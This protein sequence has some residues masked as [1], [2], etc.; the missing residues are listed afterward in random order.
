MGALA[1][2]HGISGCLQAPMF[3]GMAR[4][5]RRSVSIRGMAGKG[6]RPT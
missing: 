4:S 6:S 1:L 2:S 3:A 5:Y